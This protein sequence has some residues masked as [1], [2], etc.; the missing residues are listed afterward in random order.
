MTGGARV[1]GADRGQPRWDMVDLDSQL[2]AEHRARIVWGFVETLDLGAFYAA[3]RSRDGHAGQ[4]AT[5]PKVLLALWLYATL[6]GVGSARALARL[7]EDHTAY[8]W[9]RG[10]AP[11]NHDL[12]SEF[13]RAH[14]D[15]LD[16]MLTRSLTALLA[17]GL[18]RMAEVAIDGTKLRAAAG[19]SSLAGRDR[20]ERLEAQV[21]A[22]IAA[23]R[24]EIEADPAA[25]EHRRRAQA[26][27]TAGEQA[28]RIAQ[29]KAR[30]DALERERAERSR[31]HSKE[32]AKKRPPKVS[33]SDPAARV[34][35]MADGA[36]RPA[37]NLQVAA[38]DGFVLAVEP[39]DRRN[40]TGLAQG[41]LDQVR[42]RC[43]RM[44]DRLLADTRCIVQGDITAFAER[45]P[46]MLVYAPPPPDKADASP[47][48]LRKRAW[49]RAREPEPVR[50]WRTR[51]A[52]DEGQQIYARR[53]HIERAHAQ[54]KN[55]GLGRL[56]VRGL[57]KV[58]AVALLHA[59]AHNLWHAHRLRHPP[60]PAAA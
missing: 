39:T 22:R 21:A 24:A 38:A 60:M 52:S 10:G 12:L 15:K 13:R 37:W 57:E 53:K 58:R 34:M 36:T 56:L 49:S 29:A 28:R 48:S 43:G 6:E 5:D 46:T 41:L 9:L 35:R 18:V 32:E 51:M 45:H 16:R 11:V 17:E 14:G 2:P 54:M 8:R 26:L 47:E 1:I 20:L 50:H 44:P 30:L 31:R 27:A 40:D 4:P 42:R 55:R 33:T 59:I 25:A 19:P 7:S 3:I 23:L